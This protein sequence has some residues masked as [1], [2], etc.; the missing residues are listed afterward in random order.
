MKDKTYS[1]RISFNHGNSMPIDLKGCGKL[2]IDPGRDYFFE[3]A[4]IKFI[5]YLAQLRRLGVTYQITNDK[6]GCYKTV[7][8]STYF[9]NDPLKSMSAFRNN[10]SNKVVDPKTIRKVKPLKTA[11]KQQMDEQ[12]IPDLIPKNTFPSQQPE[13]TLDSLPNNP[14]TPEAQPHS[15]EEGKTPEDLT[16]Q[17]QDITEGSDNNGSTEDKTPEPPKE[18]DIEVLN[19]PDL[20]AYAHELGLS[21]VSEINTKKEIKE[22]IT[23]FKQD[24]V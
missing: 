19:K 2:Q 7:N 10:A 9:S 12:E 18:V 23:K 13:V 17:T 8:L 22:L 21:D 14:F 20:I 6:K 5:N 16:G 1:V 11:I 4:P 24:Q 15:D 3:K